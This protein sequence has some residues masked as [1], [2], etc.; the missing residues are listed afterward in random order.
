MERGAVRRG[1]AASFARLIIQVLDGIAGD[2]RK[3]GIEWLAVGSRR[4]GLNH[5]RHSRCA[6]A[7][8]AERVR[9]PRHW[10]VF[11]L[12]DD[13]LES[14]L[15]FLHDRMLRSR[16]LRRIVAANQREEP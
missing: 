4:L 10:I 9:Q 11:T 13:G 16:A 3:A 6:I 7:D 12:A 15:G 5:L 2:P 1:R 14:I 8:P